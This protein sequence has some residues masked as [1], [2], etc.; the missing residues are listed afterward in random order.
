METDPQTHMYHLIHDKSDT[1]VLKGK[2]TL[3][4]KRLS[5]LDGKTGRRKKKNLSLTIHK[6]HFQIDLNVK[7]KTIQLS[8][9]IKFRVDKDFF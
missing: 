1:T 5:Q 4:N 8:V 6:K 9:K 2:N 3:F 7:S